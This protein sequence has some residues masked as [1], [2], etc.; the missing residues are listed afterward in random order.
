MDLHGT[1]IIG[2][3]REGKIAIA[4]DGQATLGEQVV[5]KSHAVKVR[6]IYN[7]KVVVGFAGGVADAFSLCNKFEELLQK[8]SGN[9]MRSAVELAIGFR[10]DKYSR[11]SDAVM[12]VA[13][14]TNMLMLTNTGEVIE[15]DEDVI[16]TGSGGNFAL[17]AGRA[18]M[19]HTKMT[20]KEIALA[21]INIAADI[22]IFT[23]HNITIE[24]V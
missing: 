13:D 10:D 3:K 2:V 9:L 8:F 6:R 11:H 22:C 16:A 17:A 12:I 21:S 19:E 4:G 20:A 7:G 23:N 15:P 14:K 24:E 5:L 1:T 18:L